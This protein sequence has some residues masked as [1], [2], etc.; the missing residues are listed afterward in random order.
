MI[1]KN[2]DEYFTIKVQNT[3]TFNVTLNIDLQGDYIKASDIKQN[4][5]GK[6]F[7][8]PYLKDGNFHIVIFTWNAPILD[9]NLSEKMNNT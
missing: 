9:M 3:T 2:C 7:S 5:N 4:D 8:V 1:L 6:V